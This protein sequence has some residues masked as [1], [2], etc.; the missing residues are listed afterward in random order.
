M[1]GNEYFGLLR[2]LRWTH[3]KAAQFFGVSKWTSIAWRNNRQQVP[4]MVELS[5]RCE[6]YRQVSGPVVTA[7]VVS[8]MEEGKRSSLNSQ[9]YERAA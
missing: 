3:A 6:F 2:Q 8:L 9:P 1:T 5:L 4:H 7:L